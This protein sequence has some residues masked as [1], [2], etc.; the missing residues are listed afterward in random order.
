MKNIKPPIGGIFF[1]WIFLIWSDVSNIFKCEEIRS[2]LRKNIKVIN[3][4][5]EKKIKIRL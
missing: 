5:T 4:D 2:N 1:L 3:N